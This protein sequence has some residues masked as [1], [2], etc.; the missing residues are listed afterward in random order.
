MFK[1]FLCDLYVNLNLL[2]KVKCQKIFILLFEHYNRI[3]I[4]A[5]YVGEEHGTNKGGWTV[6][7]FRMPSTRIEYVQY[8]SHNYCNNP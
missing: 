8:T 4:K 3:L 2:K 6:S 1:I 7:D 5:L